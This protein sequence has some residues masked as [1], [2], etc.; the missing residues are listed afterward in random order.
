M[1][2]VQLGQTMC[3]VSL[4]CLLSLYLTRVL[5]VG[6]ILKP[7]RFPDS[8]GLI[9]ELQDTTRKEKMP[10]QHVWKLQKNEEWHSLLCKMEGG[11]QVVKNCLHIRNTENQMNAKTV[12]VQR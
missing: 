11:V 1:A 8:R 3:I 10:L 12:K 9:R 4:V 7:E 5:D 2:K 6:K